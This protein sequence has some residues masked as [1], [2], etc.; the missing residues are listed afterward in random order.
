MKILFIATA[1][2]VLYLMRTKYKLTY[3]QEHDTFRVTFLLAMAAVLAL[4]V[5]GVGGHPA[6]AVR[7]ADHR[8][9]REPHQPLPVRPG[10]LPRAVR[11]QLGVPI[12][13]RAR[14][15]AAGDVG[16][17]HHS[18]RAVCRLFLLLH[19]EPASRPQVET[20]SLALIDRATG[21]APDGGEGGCSGACSGAGCKRIERPTRTR[22]CVL[23]S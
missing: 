14:L 7:V 2:Y 20:A 5:V 22:P 15:L 9:V 23:P 16:G 12:P 13:D 1:A 17:G 19:S 4:F 3:D 11:A 8:R 10:R 21:L 18:D 6:A